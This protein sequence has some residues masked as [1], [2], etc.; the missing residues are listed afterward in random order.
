MHHEKTLGIFSLVRGVRGDGG[1]H[2]PHRGA[3]RRRATRLDGQLGGRDAG[4]ERWCAGSEL[5]G[6]GIADRLGKSPDQ[7]IYLGYMLITWGIIGRGF[8]SLVPE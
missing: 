3:G 4:G 6:P 8:R 7:I 2:R 1:S 5:V